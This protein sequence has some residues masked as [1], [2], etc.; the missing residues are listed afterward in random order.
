MKHLS[1][2]LLLAATFAAD[3]SAADADTAIGRQLDSLDQTYEIDE[4]GDYRLLF[5]MGGDR[6]QLVFVRSP[7]Y[8]YGTH[9][10]REIWS[11]AYRADNGAFPAFVANHLLEASYETKL[12]AWTKNGDYAMFV[13]KLPVR[14][15]NE[16][17]ADAMEAAREA[18]DRMEIELTGGGDE[19]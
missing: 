3:V 13:V 14:A 15:S 19:F 16:E 17:L 2:V 8:Q 10:V 4:D 11:P 5:D 12:G 1:A 18:A 9:E 6:T 7:V